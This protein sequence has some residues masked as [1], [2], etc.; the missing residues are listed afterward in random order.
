MTDL[1]QSKNSQKHGHGPS[2]F[3]FLIVDIIANFF[4]FARCG[5]VRGIYSD[6]T[7]PAAIGVVWGILALVEL[8]AHIFLGMLD[9]LPDEHR[10]KQ[11]G[12]KAKNVIESYD[13]ENRADDIREISRFHS[14]E[15]FS[16]VRNWVR[17]H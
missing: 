10:E 2:L 7:V 11:F 13:K 17:P 8:V 3:D 4:G 16:K 14:C 12:E 15:F 5:S 9:G 6:L 1:I